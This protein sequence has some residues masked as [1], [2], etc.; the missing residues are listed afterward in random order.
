M[1]GFKEDDGVGVNIGAWV[2]MIEPVG[3]RKL[4]SER[5]I[6]LHHHTYQGVYVNVL[7]I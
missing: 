4:N 7:Y 5:N 6:W 3:M 2:L 1:F